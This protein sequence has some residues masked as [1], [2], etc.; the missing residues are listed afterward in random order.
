MSA[1]GFNIKITTTAELQALKQMEQELIRNITAARAAGQSL[2]EYS[3][4]A[5]QLESVQGRMKDLGFGAR[6]KGEIMGAAQ[7]V[8]IFGRVMSAANGSA[9]L[10]SLGLAGLT[11]AALG[12]R[13]AL[14]EFSK[15]EDLQT[16]FITLLGSKGAAKARMDELNK[17][18][19]ATPFELPEVAQASKVLENLTGG[20]LST[21]A[22]LRMV[23]DVAAAA[24][25]SFGEVAVTMGRLYQGMRDGTP[26]GE[27]AARMTELTGINLR[28]AKSWEEVAAALGK[29]NGEMAR[30]SETASGKESTFSDSFNM[31]MSQLGRP[32]APAYKGA[33]GGTAG[34]LEGIAS[35]FKKGWDA[36][37]ND[38]DTIAR[39]N[40]Q[41]NAAETTKKKV[42]GLAAAQETAAEKTKRIKQA[43]SEA[44]KPL[45]EMGD[46]A[47]RASKSFE[48]LSA[49]QQSLALSKIDADEAS[50]KI[51]APE[52]A[53]KRVATKTAFDLEANS[54]AMSQ[55]EAELAKAKELADSQYRRTDIAQQMS[56]FHPSPKNSKEFD[57]AQKIQAELD[58]VVANAQ[59]KVDALRMQREEIENRRDKGNLEI[60]SKSDKAIAAG[61]EEA[62]YLEAKAAGD[63]KKLGEFEWMRSF[64]AEIDKGSTEWDARR[65][66][67]M[68][69]VDDPEKAKKDAPDAGELA[70]R[71]L[72]VSSMARIG[73]AVGESMQAAGNVE[74]LRK[75]IEHTLKIKE[76]TEAT[77][78]TT[79]E[80][81]KKGTTYQ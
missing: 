20:A 2:K 13:K 76:A 32:F 66:A 59:G 23:G 12:L 8:P 60:H 70:R 51:A 35:G 69:A 29:Y 24:D 73:G 22:G 67:N 53:L 16:T 38:Q 43:I 11:G 3:A 55:S 71:A 77:A 27:A 54:K 36:Y 61:A 25:A 58:A 17:F 21:G 15:I 7:S 1:T 47:D 6:L 79:K 18:A 26:F 56:I 68:K 30:R 4:A 14:S 31:L 78:K 57:E 72:S 33:L 39:A 62:A 41:G 80:L 74:L 81:L 42:E 48:R 65:I 44:V 64:Q 10:L 37:E 49:A 63:K 19:A 40:G 50:G 75:Q 5:R 34:L 9:G 45:E 28:Q 52:A 46:A